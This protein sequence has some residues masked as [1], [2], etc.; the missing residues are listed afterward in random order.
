MKQTVALEVLD[1]LEPT[2]TL[3]FLKYVSLNFDKI[4]NKVLFYIWV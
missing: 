1:Q 2:E 4:R 3:V